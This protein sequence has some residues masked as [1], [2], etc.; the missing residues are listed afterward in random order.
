[1]SSLKDQLFTAGLTDKQSVK[2]A[3]KKK[4]AKI[5]KKQR[6]ALSDS[7]KLAEQIRLEKA[8]RDKE[9][10]RQRQQ[11][12]EK[13][14]LLAQVKQ[15]VESS[16]IER[17]DADIAYSFTFDKKVKKLY[18]SV[19]QQRQLARG[20]VNIIALT[21]E[22]FELVPNVVAQKIA[23]RDA[24]YIVQNLAKATDESEQDD[25]YADYQIPDD[26]IW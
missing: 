9:L 7:A 5:P 11:K 25:P 24:S 26:L 23:Q 13:K 4:Q 19:E 17:D 22:S 21:G 2:N 3:R 16:K 10:N 12:I 15:L 14:A 18:V 6:G 20:Q 8:Q 1:M